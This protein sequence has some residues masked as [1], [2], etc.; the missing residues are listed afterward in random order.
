MA[1]KP[2]PPGSDRRQQILEA[3]LDLFA[4]QGLAGATS[5]DIAERAEVTHGLIYFYFK[6][7]EDLY[8]AAFEYALERAL[9]QLDLSALAHSDEPP[10]VAL[11]PLL[12]R[13]LD[14][15]HSPTLMSISRLMM[16][17]MAH[18]D[19]RDGPLYDCKLRMRETVD[20][21]VMEVRD[22]LDRQVAL[23][24]LRPV[25]TQVVAMFLVG[26][27][28]SSLR[29]SHGGAQAGAQAGGDPQAAAVA[30]TDTLM[31]GLRLVPQEPA[32][33]PPDALPDES[34]AAPALAGTLADAS[35][36]V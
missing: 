17:T 1:R 3:A 23:G 11:T 36:A 6:S 19:W 20:L 31:R 14:T 24:R 29:W 28:A 15:L 12:A 35:S 18:H 32:S 13:F 30:I 25:N 9:K 16:H 10:E 5:K 7:K 34:R 2:A 8:K 22:Y 4:E 27:V 26:G 21:I 33:G